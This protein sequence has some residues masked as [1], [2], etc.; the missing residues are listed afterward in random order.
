MKWDGGTGTA[1]WAGGMVRASVVA[2]HGVCGSVMGRANACWRGRESEWEQR[3]AVARLH[4]SMHTQSPPSSPASHLGI[5]PPFPAYPA[6]RRHLPYI[7]PTVAIPNAA[8][9]PPPSPAHPAHRRHPQRIPPTS[10][11]HPANPGHRRH[12]PPRESRSQNIP[13]RPV[14]PYPAPNSP[15]LNLL[16]ISRTHLRP[17]HL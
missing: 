13:P 1:S 16:L 2:A 8:R 6:H 15:N 17:P 12:P 10:A 14:P 3:K 11:T 9:L 4:G 5:P 7:P